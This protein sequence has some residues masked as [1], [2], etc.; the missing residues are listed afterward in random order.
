M[1]GTGTTVLATAGTVALGLWA[2]DK[3][4]SMKFVVGTG[5]YAAAVAIIGEANP[6][7]AAKF[8]LLV[9]I[10]ALLF[11]GPDALQKLGLINQGRGILSGLGGAIGRVAGVTPQQGLSAR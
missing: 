9:F 8:A 3:N 1:I 6:E 7:F 11:Y 2:Q 4:I 5:I 10:S